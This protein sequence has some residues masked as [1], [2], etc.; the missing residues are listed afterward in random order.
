[1]SPYLQSTLLK[2]ALTVAGIVLVLVVARLRKLSLRDD[3]GFRWPPPR[4]LA[5]WMAL[6]IAWMVVGEALIDLFGLPDPEPWNAGYSTL[7]VALRIL[8]IGLLGP[9]SEEML[10][11]GMVFWRLRRTPLGDYGAIVVVAALWAAF[12]TQYGFGLIALIFLDGLVLGLARV[13]TRSLW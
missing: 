5:L 4:Q 12:H 13:R 2:V 8:A 9:I 1:M 6:W 10:M 3:L 7:I 11:R